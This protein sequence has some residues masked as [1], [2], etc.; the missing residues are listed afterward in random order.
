MRLNKG[1]VC[2][3]KKL[4]SAGRIKYIDT[5]KAF[6]ICFVI[7]GHCF[8][9]QYICTYIYSFHMP[10]FFILSG[11][12][13]KSGSFKEFV[14]KKSFSLLLPYF[15]FCLAYFLKDTGV[16]I[17]SHSFDKQAVVKEFLGIFLC[18][19]RTEYMINGLWFLPCLFVA[20]VLFF[21]IVKYIKNEKFILL[22]SFLICVFQYIMDRI[23][24]ISLVWC[25]DVA[26]IVL[27]F[28]AF[29][30]VFN[31]KLDYFVN[32][33]SKNKAVCI[34]MSI[35]LLAVGYIVSVMNYN[36][37]SNYVQFSNGFYGELG[38]MLISALFSVSAIILLSQNFSTKLSLFIGKNSLFIYAFHYFLFMGNVN[39]RLVTLVSPYMNVNLAKMICAFIFMVFALV[40]SLAFSLIYNKIMNK[41]KLKIFK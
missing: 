29:G 6:G 32:S 25:F 39:E 21:V 22:T 13:F 19:E 20:E 27:I 2:V 23:F 1:V 30:Y 3:E 5:A 26:L 12:T 17:L 35:V 40:I 11:L 14:K 4:Q 31:N 9:P 33:F 8:L 36:I 10:L 24:N 18:I 37:S 41:I 28:V 15:L 38:L 34:M 16:Q 7:L